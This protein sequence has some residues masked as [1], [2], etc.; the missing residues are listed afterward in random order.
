MVE[1]KLSKEAKL[2]LINF[3]QNESTDAQVKALLLDGEITQLDKQSEEIVNARFESH[4]L[5]EGVWKSV[6]G[7]IISL[8]TW[9]LYRAIRATLQDKSRKC[10]TFK[11]GAERDVCMAEV[12]LWEVNQMEKIIAKAKSECSKYKNPEKC[13][14]LADKAMTKNKLKKAKAETKLHNLEMKGK[15]VA[16]GK[17]M[18]GRKSVDIPASGTGGGSAGY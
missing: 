14:A 2:Q 6:F 8:G 3:I 17:E 10:G 9:P 16:R 13:R 15:G 5:N 7:M 18:A 11:V 4:P 1:S 12:T